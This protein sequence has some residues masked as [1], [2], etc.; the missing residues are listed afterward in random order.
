MHLFRQNGETAI[1]NRMDGLRI[2][3]LGERAKADHIGKEHGDLLALAF[4]RT[5]GSQNFLCEILRR[6]GAWLSDWGV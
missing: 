5:A 4:Q 1:H 3:L 6:V 2:G